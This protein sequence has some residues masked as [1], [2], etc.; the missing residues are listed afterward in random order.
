MD[1]FFFLVCLPMQIFNIQYN[2][3]SFFVKYCKHKMIVEKNFVVV[4]TDSSA[5]RCQHNGFSQ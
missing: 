1:F 3:S 4:Y 2:K 5:F